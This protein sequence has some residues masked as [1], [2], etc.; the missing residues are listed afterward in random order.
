MLYP[1][2]LQ[3][4]CYWGGKDKNSFCMKNLLV[5]NIFKYPENCPNANGFQQ[6][7]FIADQLQT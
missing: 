5:K 2:E 6:F 3:N 7:N 4:H 1:I